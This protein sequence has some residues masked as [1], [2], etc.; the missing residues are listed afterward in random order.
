[1][2]DPISLRFSDSVAADLKLL[3]SMTGES[4]TGLIRSM[5]EAGTEQMKRTQR[6]MMVRYAEA[7]ASLFT[8]LVDDAV[9]PPEVTE[10]PQRIGEL[11]FAQ[12]VEAWTELTR[13]VQ[14]QLSTLS[15]AHFVV[16]EA[17]VAK[18]V[19]NRLPAKAPVGEAMRLRRSL[20]GEK[21]HRELFG[22]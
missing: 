6:E 17:D 18:H 8:S 10:A 19:V 16:F 3:S 11:P 9:A 1:M 5:V 2:A 12:A 14:E 21:R 22:V 15:D 13:A 20:L 7:V 4:Q